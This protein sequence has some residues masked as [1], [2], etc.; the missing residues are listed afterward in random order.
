VFKLSYG[1]FD[2]YHGGDAQYDGCSTFVWKD[3]ETTAA[4]AAGQVDVM[5][6]D[7]HGVTNTNGYGFVAKNGHVCD[8][9][10]HLDPRCWII[11]SWTDGH[12]RQPVYEGVTSLLPAMDIFITN[13]C[14]AM[15][16]Y[17]RFGQVK[18]SDGHI[19]VRVE[20]GGAH[21]FIYTLTDSD[22]KKTVKKISGPYTSR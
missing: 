15:R 18:G 22:G 1:K 3:M 5:K 13:S 19:V 20:K 11:N 8:A 21:Y 7:H 17:E 16:S 6:A 2:F 14:D 12:P 4:K 9:I 10:K